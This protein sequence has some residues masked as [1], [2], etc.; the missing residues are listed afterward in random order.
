M[1]IDIGPKAVRAPRMDVN[2]A[3]PMRAPPDIARGLDVIT[4]D[5]GSLPFRGLSTVSPKFGDGWKE[6]VCEALL[7]TPLSKNFSEA[8][9]YG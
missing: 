2:T 9:W 7:H 6:R 8:S 4:G 1:S 5:L 3:P